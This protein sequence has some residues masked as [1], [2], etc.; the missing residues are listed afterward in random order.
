MWH[1]ENLFLDK[2]IKIKSAVYVDIKTSNINLIT[3]VYVLI[4]GLKSAASGYNGSRKWGMGGEG[5]TEC[6]TMCSKNKMPKNMLTFKA[7]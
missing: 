2:K 7:T 3:Y 4:N 5:G 1:K 6:S